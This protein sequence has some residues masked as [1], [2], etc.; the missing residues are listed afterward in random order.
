[1]DADSGGFRGEPG[2]ADHLH[3]VGCGLRG[4][5][6]F[7]LYGHPAALA[8]RL[9]RLAYDRIPGESV[10]AGWG[11]DCG[12]AD[13]PGG[14]VGTRGSDV[15]VERAGCYPRAGNTHEPVGGRGR[16]RSEERRVGK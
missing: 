2:A 7:Q 9:A 16:F 6:A 12:A 8:V 5:D 15:R 11:E 10:R 4:F 14:P 3:S 13:G 1:M